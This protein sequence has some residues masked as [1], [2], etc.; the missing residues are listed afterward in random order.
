MASLTTPIQCY[1]TGARNNCYALVEMEVTSLPTGALPLTVEVSGEFDTRE[2]SFNRSRL[3]FLSNSLFTDAQYAGIGMGVDTQ[4][5]VLDSGDS[6]DP[7]YAG[8][9]W[10]AAGRGI[11]V[12]DTTKVGISIQDAG[13]PQIAS[14]SSPHATFSPTTVTLGESGGRRHGIFDMTVTGIPPGEQDIIATVATLSTTWEIPFNREVPSFFDDLSPLPTVG[15]GVSQQDT[16][17]IDQSG[18]RNLIYSFGDGIEVGD[19]TQLAIVFINTDFTEVTFASDHASFTDIPFTLPEDAVNINATFAISENVISNTMFNGLITFAGDVT[20]FDETDIQLTAVDGNGITGVTFTVTQSTPSTYALNFTLPADAEGQ[21]SIQ[22]TGTV[23]PD[24]ETTE[25]AIVANPAAP[26]VTYDTSV[27]AVATW[28]TPDYTVGEAQIRI[29]IT[30][31]S[32]V[33]VAD[34]AVFK[35]SP[36]APL[37]LSDLV[38]LEASI[39]GAGTDWVLYL[40]VPLDLDGEVS[41]DIVGE[42]FKVST[43]VYDTVTIAALTLPVNTI[44]PEVIRREQPGNYTHGQRYDVVWQF[45]V[46]VQF[47][48]P[49]DFYNDPSATPLDYFVFSGAQLGQPAFKV[50]TGTGFP[51]LPL[52]DTLPAEWENLDIQNPQ[53]SDVYLFRYL[54]IGAAV[55]GA[56]LVEVKA[57]TYFNPGT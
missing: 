24:G 10:W 11:A 47:Y 52:P 43:H 45:N 33:V 25:Q 51:T 46:G 21:F 49:E 48:N 44:I 16:E 18:N 17:R 28:G 8:S 3:S 36:V 56:S 54:A 55:A 23:L 32:D 7:Q 35:V 57:G 12:G 5:H 4:W 20:L 29:P 42:I 14:L 19:T 6:N 37:T 22:A 53:T 15:T 1:Y 27:A 39:N 40:T 41:I 2:I 38:G 50:W 34:T 31:A 13:N 9:M 26:V 30:F